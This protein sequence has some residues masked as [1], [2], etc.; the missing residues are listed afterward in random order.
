[1]TDRSHWKVQKYKLGE[2]PEI[3]EEELAMTPGQRIELCW[4]ITAAAWELHDPD[5]LREGFR[6]DI[7]RVIRG[8]S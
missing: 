4:A 6:R 1:M 2:E 8:R 3:D 5:A 7:A